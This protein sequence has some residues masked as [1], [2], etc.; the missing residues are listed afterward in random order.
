MLAFLYEYGLFL[1][2]TLTI[3]IAIVLT[4][5]AII[6]LVMRAKREEGT[7]LITSLNDK[8]DDLTQNL[9]AETLEKSQFKKWQKEQQKEAK[10]KKKKDK[11]SKAPP[12]LFVFDFDGDIKASQTHA[13]REIVSAIISIA[14]PNDQVLVIVDSAG[15]FV[16]HY[17]LAASQLH[18]LRQHDL[19]LTVAIDKCAASGGYLMACVANHIIAAPFAIVGSIGVIGQ[20][21]NFHRLLEKN[22]IDFE[23]H[24]AG[25]FKRTLTLFGENTDKGRKKFQEEIEET[26]LLFKQFIAAHRPAVDI[27]HIATGEHWHAVDAQKLKLVDDIKTSDDFILNKIPEYKIYQL[28]FEEKQ[29]LSEKLAHNILGAVEAK[30]M[31]WLR[32]RPVF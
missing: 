32:I 23:I 5:G 14:T 19:H 21:P 18:R 31:K 15:G 17:G 20:L 10:S 30:I 25:E 6:A 11:D 16:H 12:R 29:K 2:K 1:A 26:H 27:N 24:T 4:L 28:S 8:Y 3:V 7:L 13:L 9:Q 22:N